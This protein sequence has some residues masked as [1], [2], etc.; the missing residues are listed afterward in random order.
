MSKRDPAGA[1]V[2]NNSS[3]DKRTPINELCTHENIDRAID[4]INTILN[5]CFNGI[6]ARF[7][8]REIIDQCPYFGS[9]G[10]TIFPNVSP[11]F[12]MVINTYYK[13]D[14]KVFVSGD[15]GGVGLKIKDT[16]NK[17]T[18]P[19]ET[20]GRVYEPKH[21]LLSPDEIQKNL[22]HPANI[23]C[24]IN[25]INELLRTNIKG[26]TAMFDE[27]DILKLCMTLPSHDLSIRWKDC[28]YMRI[29]DMFDPFVGFVINNHFLDKWERTFANGKFCFTPLSLSSKDKK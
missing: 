24:A 19:E 6:T 10:T 29:R 9:P 25:A 13:K 4:I 20:K 16:D 2:N 27:S 11:L 17:Q 22:Y 28:D 21:V 18:P 12:V 1:G 26:E 3:S 5:R 14:W 23:A 7:S 8:M 15:K